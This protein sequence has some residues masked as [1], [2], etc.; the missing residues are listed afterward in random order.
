MHPL[1]V[2][3]VNSAGAVGSVIPRSSRK[4][5]LAKSLANA[6]RSGVPGNS[7]DADATENL[8]SSG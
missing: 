6:A 7:H 2:H 1:V 8:P 3:D 4:L 5:S